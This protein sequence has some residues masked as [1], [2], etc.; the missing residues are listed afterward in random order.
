MKQPLEIG[1]ETNGLYLVDRSSC[2]SSVA[3]SSVHSSQHISPQP[4]FQSSHTP[5]FS[6]SCQLSPLELRH[7]RLGHISFDSMRHINIVSTCNSKHQSI[8]QVCHQAKQHRSPFP[9]SN[10]CTSHIFEMLHVDIWGPYATSTYNGYKY[11]ITI[12]DDFSRATWTHLLSHKSNAFLIL[13]SFIS[14]IKTQF[15]VNVQTI[16]SDNG[17][18]FCDSSALAFYASRG[19]LHQT[20]CTGTP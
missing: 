1:R 7:C 14:F 18:E 4:L 9:I 10:S 13:K 6:F 12:V 20:S 17:Q 3:S 8:C 11:F 5:V 19:I 2:I 15:K 16:R